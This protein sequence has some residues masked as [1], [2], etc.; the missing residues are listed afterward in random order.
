MA[1]I[2]TV[3]MV[4]AL[5]VI[6]VDISS[7]MEFDSVTDGSVISP[8]PMN[9][10]DPVPKKTRTQRPSDKRLVI[11]PLAEVKV[12]LEVDPTSAPASQTTSVPSLDF[13][14]GPVAVTVTA[15]TAGFLVATVVL[16]RTASSKTFLP[17][18][19]SPW[20]AVL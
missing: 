7:S 9:H 12:A 1:M 6:P 15:D 3:M 4:V 10:G 17:W 8:L 5:A 14:A 20:H 19:P 2:T 13:V 11:T 18:L 16:R